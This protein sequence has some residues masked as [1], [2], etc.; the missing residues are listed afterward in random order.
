MFAAIM[1]ASKTPIEYPALC[2]KLNVERKRTKPIVF[3][4][5]RAGMVH[6]TAWHTDETGGMM[7]TL[8]NG[9]GSRETPHL[10]PPI[11]KR[12]GSG[13]ALFASFRAAWDALESPC[14]SKELCD[15]SGLCRNAQQ[16]MVKVLRGTGRN[17][18][19]VRICGYL[20]RDGMGG[21]PSP[22]YIRGFGDDAPRLKP[23]PK[24]LIQQKYV[25]RARKI[26]A[27]TAANQALFNGANKCA[28][29]A[30]Q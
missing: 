19:L 21:E 23:L 13:L 11:D 9:P 22:Q 3:A 7:P 5:I 30:T 18:R 28:Q 10:C 29:V 27:A 24:T 8:Q 1:L 6:A 4:M 12:N 26:Q 14:T 2:E 16:R 15:E 20:R 25:L 17:N